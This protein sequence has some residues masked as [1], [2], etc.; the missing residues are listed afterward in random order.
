MI[1]PTISISPHIVYLVGGL[2][3]ALHEL[4]F[5]LCSWFY[6]NGTCGDDEIPIGVGAEDDLHSKVGFVP[7]SMFCYDPTFKCPGGGQCH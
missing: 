2:D 6:K 4:I 3:F 7:Q 1:S 5:C